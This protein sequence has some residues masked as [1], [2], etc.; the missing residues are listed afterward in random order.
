MTRIEALHAVW[1]AQAHLYRLLP[2]K[3]WPNEYPEI[4]AALVTLHNAES[5]LRDELRNKPSDLPEPESGTLVQI[6]DVYGREWYVQRRDLDSGRLQLPLYYLTG[7]KF[8]DMPRGLRPD[9]VTIHRDNIA[10]EE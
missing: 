5:Q 4:A 6:V 8:A 9:A 1:N 3:S 7:R 10:R 2:Q